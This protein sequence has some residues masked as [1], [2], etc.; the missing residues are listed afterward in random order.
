[1]VN[2]ERIAIKRGGNE[3]H[4]VE[5]QSLVGLAPINIDVITKNQET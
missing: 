1:M 2:N 4:N 3:W 5:M